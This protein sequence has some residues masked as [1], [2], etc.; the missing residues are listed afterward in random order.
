MEKELQE[1]LP[2]LIKDHIG[3]LDTKLIT[4]YH[5]SG[6]LVYQVGKEYILKISETKE[7]LERERSVNDFLQGKVPASKTILYYEDEF[8]AFYLKTCVEGD[9]VLEDNLKDPEVAA[10]YLAEAM[11]QYHGMDLTGCDFYTPDSLSY[12]D[13]EK[14]FVHGDFCLPNILVKDGKVSG[15]IDTEASGIGDP[16]VDYAWCIW[17]FEHNLGTNQYTPMLLK[18]LGIEFDQE[19]YERYTKLD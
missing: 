9:P 7:R 12:D 17:S 18:K 6:D 13:Y 3:D 2:A 4:E 8:R 10:T 5:R 19:K 11:K 16:W 1:I 15:F 14:C